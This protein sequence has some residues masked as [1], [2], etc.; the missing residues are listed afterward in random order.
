MCLD[1]DLMRRGEISGAPK[2]DS[3]SSP[4]A[5][6]DPEEEEEDLSFPGGGG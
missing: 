6:R 4:R 2:A 3:R 1:S 5:V